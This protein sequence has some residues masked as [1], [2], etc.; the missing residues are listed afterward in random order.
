MSTSNSTDALFREGEVSGALGHSP[1]ASRFIAAATYAILVSAVSLLA[2]DAPVLVL[3]AITVASYLLFVLLWRTQF[4]PMLSFVDA[5]LVFPLV[6]V[7]YTAFPLVAFDAFAFNFGASG[8]NRLN[9]IILTDDLISTVWL[10]SNLAMAGFGGAYLIFRRSRPPQFPQRR[11]FAL[12]ALWAGLAI[13]GT[14]SVFLF[15]MRGSGGYLD[16]YAF[17]EQLPTSV[18][19]L[20][21]ISN[22]LFMASILG[23]GIVYVRDRLHLAMAVA[24]GTAVFFLLTSQARS[25]LMLDLFGILAAFDLYRRRLAP[26]VLAA[27]AVVLLTT[28]LALGLLRESGAIFTDVA[29]RNEFMAVFVTAIDIR[30]LYITGSTLDMN[31]NLLLSDFLRLVPQQLLSFEKIDPA[32][33]YVSTFYPEYAQAGGGLAFGMV[34]ESILGGGPL[35]ALLRGLALGTAVSCA[36]NYLTARASLWRAII[37]LWLLVSLYQSFRDTTFT[38][39]GRFLFQ[40]GPAVLILIVLTH[41]LPS[42]EGFS[43]NPETQR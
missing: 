26:P 27:G 18:V 39:G 41:M 3:A 12:P 36:I 38:L 16:E 15:V 35:V 10:C 19:Q 2:A 1:P 6:I 31:A 32:S 22:S 4:R 30:Q 40:F 20:V 9:S 8:D 13:S 25:S 5:G 28:F 14:V 42:R 24:A 21:N 17:I 43:A 34:S 7:L 29:G 33:W 11:N 37:Y 23:L